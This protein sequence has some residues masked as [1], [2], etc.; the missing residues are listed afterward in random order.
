[1]LAGAT[2][3]RGTRGDVIAVGWG[4]GGVRGRRIGRQTGTGLRP[5]PVLLAAPATRGRSA[6]RR[7]SSLTHDGVGLSIAREVEKRAIGV[8]RMDQLSF[9]ERAREAFALVITGEDRASGC[10]LLTKGILD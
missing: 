4:A 1:M 10:V 7:A 3:R 8:E 2:G 9:Y 6:V 5:S